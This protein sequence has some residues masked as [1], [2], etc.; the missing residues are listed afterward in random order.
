MIVLLWAGFIVFVL[1]VLAI[2]LGLFSKKAHAIS[3]GEALLRTLIGVVLAFLFSIFVYFA[4]EGHWFGLTTH[5]GTVDPAAAHNTPEHMQKLL[6]ENGTQAAVMFISGYILEQSLSLDNIFVMALILAFFSVPS[7]LQHR[8]LFWGIM[9]ALV[10]R[11]VMIGIGTAVIHQFQWVSYVFGAILVYTAFKM[12]TAGEDHIDI[13]NSRMVRFFR[14]FF[15]ISPHFD[16]EKFFT[17]LDGKFALTPMFLA[18]MVIEASDL[19]F[20]VD[21]IPAVFGVTAEPFLVF[22]SNVFAILCLRSM[23]FALADLLTKFRYLKE[24]LVTLLAYVGVKMLLHEWV[25]IPHLVSLGI[26]CGVLAL[27]VIASVIAGKPAHAAEAEEEAAEQV[28]DTPQ[29]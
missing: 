1:I 15:R 26:I 11:G 24:S 3:A 2:D 13:E 22:T 16:G 9:G 12:L 19:L 27:G 20:A 21:S 5:S 17:K 25:H 7:T 18:L 8:V 6:P 29:A 4:Y 14:Y 23:Y 28:K 10:M